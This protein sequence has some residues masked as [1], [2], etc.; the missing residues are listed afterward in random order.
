MRGSYPDGKKETFDK[1]LG[2]WVPQASLKYQLT[3]AQSLKLN[4]TT[5]IN[6]P[7]ISYLNPAVVASPTIVQQGNPH[8]S[9]S[10]TQ[11]ISLTY[12]YILPHLTLQIAPAYNFS[13]GGIS[14]IQ[15]AKDDVRYY[16][17]DNILLT[18]IFYA[19]AVSRSSN[20]Y[21]GN[22]SM[23][24]HSFSTTTSAMSITRIP[25]SAI[26]RM[27]GRTTT[28]STCHRNCLGSYSST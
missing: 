15:T 16:T 18:T 7:G 3:D 8:L 24:R 14:S 22:L 2:D 26:V 5:S 23:V 13:S 9:S 17:Y 10:H 27:G 21:N 28:I 25:I 11:R 20:M 4:F 6:R 1:H 12:A 19:I